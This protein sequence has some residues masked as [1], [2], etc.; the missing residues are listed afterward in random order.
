MK[1]I[2]SEKL[3]ITNINPI[4][5]RYYEYDCFTYPWHYHSQ[6]ELIYVEK[7]SGLCYAG[8]CIEKYADSD[9]VF[10]GDNLPHYM[11][12]DDVYTEGNKGLIVKG[13]IIQFEKDFMN[14]SINSYP[15]LLQ[16]REF[17]KASKRGIFFKNM[18]CKKILSLLEDLVVNEGF[19]QIIN[20]LNLLQKLALYP[21]KKYLASPHY[22]TL[23]PLVEDK[24]IERIIA[25]IQA[26]YTKNIS[27]K[28]I[29]D[30]AAMNPAAFCRY[31]KKQVGRSFVHYVNEMRVGY[32][33]KLL[34][35]K[36]LSVSQ[37][38]FDSGFESVNHF[39]RTFKHITSYTATQYQHRILK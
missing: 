24:R 23:F 27:L 29:A 6:F 13:I 32:A 7:S 39:N 8:D 4:K 33:C 19:Q 5:A 9:L 3:Q 36:E 12:S 28:D 1:T 38:A 31:F 26:N 22:Q 35:T 25:Y 37:I 15:Q 21:H 18:K 14:Y 34:M 11:R 10:L 2:M 17:L 16:I 30:K 20:L